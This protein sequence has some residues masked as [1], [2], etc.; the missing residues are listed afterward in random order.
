MAHLV[1]LVA[2]A[3]VFGQSLPGRETAAG[4]IRLRGEDFVLARYAATGTASGYVG[5]RLG[6]LTL[7]GGLIVNTKTDARTAIFGGGT[8]MRFR[9]GVDVG[10]LAAAASVPDGVQTRFYVMPRLVRRPFS[11]SGVVTYIEPVHGHTAR[12]L[13][14]NPMTFGVRLLP[15]FQLGASA[16]EEWTAGKP[17]RFR[18]GPMAQVRS[19][20]GN[21]SW[22]GFIPPGTRRVETRVSF[23]M[24]R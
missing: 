19:S 23:A 6:R 3:R 13:S 17:S 20:L 18:A 14:L 15:K 21:F 2:T 4:G 5:T 16:V 24:N 10:L 12:Q 11:F 7:M 22:E 1:M 9:R 8:R